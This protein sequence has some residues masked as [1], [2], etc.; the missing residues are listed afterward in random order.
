MTSFV[1]EDFCQ[2]F[3]KFLQHVWNH[4]IGGKNI[5]VIYGH[6]MPINLGLQCIELNA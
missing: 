4:K 6:E 2:T 5:P 1:S 3:I